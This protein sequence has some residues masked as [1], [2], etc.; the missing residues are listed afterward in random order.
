MHG[1]TVKL[2][3]VPGPDDLHDASADVLLSA[4]H[5]HSGCLGKP[6]APEKTGQ[7]T[8]L[9]SVDWYMLCAV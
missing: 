6:R 3:T 1:G 2:Y 4:K 5:L 9:C 7:C 8:V